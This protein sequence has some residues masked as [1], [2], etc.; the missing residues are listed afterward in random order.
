LFT[1][2]EIYLRNVFDQLDSWLVQNPYQRGI[3]WTSALEVASR[4][5][6]W[7]WLYHF[8]GNHMPRD[9]RPRLLDSLYQH[10]C[11]IENNLSF[12]FSPNTHLLGEAVALYALGH[13]FPSFPR[14]KQWLALGNKT[15]L[16]Q[17][18]RQ[19]RPDGSHFEQSTY[20]HVY[21]LDM[22]L[23]HAVV[24]HPGRAYLEK[25]A[26]MAD[27]LDALMGPERSLPF[28]GGS[29]GGRWFRPYGRRR[30]FGGA[31]TLLVAAQLIMKAQRDLVLAGSKAGGHVHLRLDLEGGLRAENL[32][33]AP[34]VTCATLEEVSSR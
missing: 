16:E 29:D 26:R 19:V 13:S 11:H 27:F 20:Y 14:A 10:G 6:S 7:M 17:I 9:L 18:E 2:N 12:Y 34:G 21:A 4:A 28:L 8:A 25:L 31:Q 23:F 15:V 33:L 22:F 24:S 32:P 1:G 30:Q 3:N 5:F